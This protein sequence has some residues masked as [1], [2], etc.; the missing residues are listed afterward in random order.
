MQLWKFAVLALAGLVMAACSRAP[1]AGP[2]GATPLRF[3]TDWRAEAELGGYYQALAEGDYARHGLAV[4]IVPGGP[5]VNVPQLVASGAVDLGV[6]SNSFIVM[7]LAA[8]HVP[9]RAVAAFMQKDPQVLI[10]HPDAGIASLADMKGH[11]ILLADASVSAFWLWLKAKYGL[12]DDQVRKYNFNN[13]PF[14]ADKRVVEQGYVTSEPYTL[15]KEG[16][17]KPAVFLL[18]DQGYPG[19]AGMVLASDAL[20]AKSPAAVRA[21]VAASAEGWKS[22]LTGDPRPGDGLILKDNPEMTEDVLA[23]ARDK[24]RRYGIVSSGDAATGGLGA[25]TDARWRTFFAMASGEGVYPK[26]LDWKRAYT[27]AFLPTGVK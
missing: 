23:Q 6:G 24:M 12:T 14:L 5:G 2:H 26:A 18:A 1:A 15:E 4:S 22:Y 19:Y 7:N 10:A 13:A 17:M 25:M 20:I 3:S 8:E 16:H 27:T 21:F 11:P 9:V